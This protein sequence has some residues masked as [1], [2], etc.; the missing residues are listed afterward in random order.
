MTGDDT[1]GPEVDFKNHPW[2]DVTALKHNYKSM[3]GRHIFI[4]GGSDA[5]TISYQ[6]SIHYKFRG[7]RQGQIYA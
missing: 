1:Q 4:T 6:V 3:N 2:W 5:Q 7:L